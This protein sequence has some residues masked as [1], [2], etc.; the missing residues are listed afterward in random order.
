ML[1]NFNDS[2]ND[3][4]LLANFCKVV[5]CKVNLIEFNHT[6]NDILNKSTKSNTEAFYNFL[7]SKNMIINIR[8]SR[9]EDIDAACGQLANTVRKNVSV[10]RVSK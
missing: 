6:G 2:L 8:N 7:E 5:P 10:H 4:K 3:A 1:K 9:G